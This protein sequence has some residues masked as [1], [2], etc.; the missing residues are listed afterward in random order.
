MKKFSNDDGVV[1]V[2]SQREFVTLDMLVAAGVCYEK[3]NDKFSK[4]DLN[5]F[6]AIRDQL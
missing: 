1:L 4:K 6:R 5:R 2:M 3:D